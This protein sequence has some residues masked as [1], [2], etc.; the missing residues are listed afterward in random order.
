MET[1]AAETSGAFLPPGGAAFCMIVTVMMLGV[2]GIDMLA[3]REGPFF[4]C[5]PCTWRVCPVGVS[6]IS[7]VGRG[8]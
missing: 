7:G 5:S 4:P 3:G 8:A 6:G 1:L 2:L